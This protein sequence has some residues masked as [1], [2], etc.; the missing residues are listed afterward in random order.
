MLKQWGGFMTMCINKGSVSGPTISSSPWQCCCSKRHPVPRNLDKNFIVGL[1]Q[2]PLIRL[3]T[4]FWLPVTT[5][6]LWNEY[7]LWI[8]KYW[9]C[10][11]KYEPIQRCF[12]GYKM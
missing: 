12:S 10:P 8:S 11:E 9:K 3:F 1:E 4:R 7:V 6:S 5:D 2:P